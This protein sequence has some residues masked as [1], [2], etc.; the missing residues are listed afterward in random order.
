LPKLLEQLPLH[1]SA[2]SNSILCLAAGYKN[3][4]GIMTLLRVL[5]A[6]LTRNME[7]GSD[8][9]IYGEVGHIL[10]RTRAE[11]RCR[12]PHQTARTLC[13][14]LSLI[15]MTERTVYSQRHCTKTDITQM[16]SHE[17]NL[18]LADTLF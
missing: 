12:C 9:N 14:L 3:L 8:G 11:L 1:R 15:F 10:E 6:Q 7:M 4:K 5:T 16:E 13:I 2:S 17:Q 18:H